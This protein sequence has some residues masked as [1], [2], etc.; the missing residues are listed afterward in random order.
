MTEDKFARNL[1][2]AAV[3]DRVFCGISILP[4]LLNLSDVARDDCKEIDLQA[5]DGGRARCT[6]KDVTCTSRGLPQDQRYV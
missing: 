4:V 6:P 5:L 3:R 1:A 2:F